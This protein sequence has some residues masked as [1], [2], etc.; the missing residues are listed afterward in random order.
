[1]RGQ[2]KKPS[3]GINVPVLLEM[4]AYISRHQGVAVP[5]LMEITGLS[6]PTVNRYLSDALH[7]LG[8][9]VVWR[10]DFSLPAGGEY[11]IAS[12]GVLNQRKVL[13]QY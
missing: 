3:K 7:H 8:V 1:M 13:E 5:E 4:L 9:E 6:K 11:T 2:R 10:R 12:W